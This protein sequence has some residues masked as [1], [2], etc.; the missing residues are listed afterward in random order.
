MILFASVLVLAFVL[1]F[2]LGG[3][4][5]GFEGVRF[6]WWWLA[7]VGL[8]VQFV[9]L[10]EGVGGTDLAVRTVVL[11]ISYAL[12]VL[13]AALNVRASGMLL[14]LIGLV[15]NLAV[16]SANG[17]MP[18]SAQALRDSD[19]L[20]VLEQLQRS[21]ADKHHLQTEDDVLT[22][23]GDI[24]AIPGPVAQAISIGD[25]LVYLGL[26]WLIV[27]AMR[28]RIQSEQATGSRGYR[29]KHRPG[30]EPSGSPPDAHVRASL[31]AATTSG[32]EP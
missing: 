5:S 15:L 9:P 31:P 21:G 11:S 17:G 20:D 28:G 24:V 13:F 19:Q 7:L 2:A 25:V 3:R 4:L 27:A 6:R 26:M 29:G 32:T 1:G 14:V 22:P 23:L 18:V 30:S 12:L 10:P 16:I 8:A